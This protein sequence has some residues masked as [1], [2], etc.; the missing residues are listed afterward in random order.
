MRSAKP[1]SDQSSEYSAPGEGPQV[2]VRGTAS[3]QYLEARYDFLFS[4]PL[5]R[6]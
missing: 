3:H 2:V 5:L 4:T 1:L 6:R